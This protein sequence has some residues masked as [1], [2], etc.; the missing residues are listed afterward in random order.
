[1][2]IALSALVAA[3]A[4]MAGPAVVHAQAVDADAVVTSHG[5]WTLKQREDWLYDRLDTAHDDGS[6]GSDEFERVH[7]EIGAIRRDEDKLR[8]SH[9]GQLTDNETAAL[10]ARLDS[11]A[12]QIHWLR[13]SDFRRPW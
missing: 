11:V 5:D 6:V 4:L 10:E 1:M 2:K 9:D 7:H 3:A 12:D 8:S 13:E